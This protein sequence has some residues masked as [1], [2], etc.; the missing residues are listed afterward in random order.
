MRSPASR[1]S[2]PPP[3]TH[4]P[5]P[6]RR[7]GRPPHTAQDTLMQRTVKT[8]EER[9]WPKVNKTDG[10]WLWIGA[11]ST[12]GYGRIYKD[13]AVQP[14]HRASYEIHRGPI[15]ANSFVCHHCD[16]PPCVNPDHL[17]LGNNSDNMKD[18]WN[19]KRSPMKPFHGEESNL[20][21][22]SASQVLEIIKLRENGLSGAN[23]ARMFR[24]TPGHVRLIIRKE[25]WSHL[26][27][28]NLKETVA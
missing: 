13:H 4:P 21:R 11:I 2:T 9:F 26:H 18:M 27:N 23:V 22:L 5:A 6:V 19:K 12:A 14:A 25:V 10:C 1:S 8:L 24:V 15:P 20:A 3:D 7:G 16:N 28:S 17:F